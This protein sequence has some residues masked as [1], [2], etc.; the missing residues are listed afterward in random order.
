MSGDKIY[1]YHW[2]KKR[3]QLLYTPFKKF[4]MIGFNCRKTANSSAYI[5][6]YPV[7]RCFCNLQP[8]VFNCHLCSGN[9]EL[10]K[11]VHFL[12]LFFLDKVC[13]IEILYLSRNLRRELRWIE[14]GYPAH[15]GFSVA[16]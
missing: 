4:Y 11:P 14:P 1:Y 5:Y 7:S 10:D 12:Y 15:S 9:S 6:T 16:P 8:R 13:R 3:G 2:N